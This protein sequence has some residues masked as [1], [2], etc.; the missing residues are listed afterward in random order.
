MDIDEDDGYSDDDLDALP[1]EDFDELQQDA[2]RS[3]QQLAPQRRPAHP[4]ETRSPNALPEGLGENLRHLSVD[5]QPLYNESLALPDYP[6]Q[7]SSDYGEFDD[8]MLDGE[9]FDAGEVSGTS[10]IKE[11]RAAAVPVG[12]ATQREIWRQQRYAIPQYP[13][14]E[15][16]PWSNAR[17]DSKPGASIRKRPAVRSATLPIEAPDPAP[18]IQ[19]DVAALQAQL[20]EVCKESCCAS[21]FGF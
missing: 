15:R 4:R 8:E 21:G 12:E 1:H 13:I 20:Q 9:I 6:N 14:N 11:S 5:A 16:P 18:E 19:T 17:S 10:A 7:P 2:I 3:T